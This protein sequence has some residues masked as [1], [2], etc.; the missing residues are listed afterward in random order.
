MKTAFHGLGQQLCTFETAAT[1]DD[2]G[3]VCKMADGGV[4]VCGAGDDVCGVLCDVRAGAAA[5]QLRGYVELPYTGTAPTAGYCA[6]T[7]DGAGGVQCAE[8]AHEFLVLSV[9]ETA[10]TVGVW[11]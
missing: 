3:K 2:L 1:A 5:V 10:S 4:A 6:L 7:A 8:G 9:D 11:L